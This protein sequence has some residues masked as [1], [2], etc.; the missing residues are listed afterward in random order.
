MITHAVNFMK[1]HMLNCAIKLSKRLVAANKLRLAIESP[2]DE[3]KFF[4]C[5]F[6]VIER[7]FSL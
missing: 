6:I 5:E 3:E 1:Q 7:Y 4:L 2:V